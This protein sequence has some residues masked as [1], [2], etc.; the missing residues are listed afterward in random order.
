M[1]CNIQ[2]SDETWGPGVDAIGMK[3][4]YG[5]EYF[6]YSNP[7]WQ[8]FPELLLKTNYRLFYGVNAIFEV[9]YLQGHRPHMVLE[10][11]YTVNNEFIETAKTSVNSTGWHVMIGVGYDFGWKTS[12]L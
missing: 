12:K 3:H 1:I 7:G 4:I 9:S 8:I 10:T 5:Y 11:T 2:Y 6:S